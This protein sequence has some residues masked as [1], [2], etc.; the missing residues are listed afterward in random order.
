MGVEVEVLSGKE[1]EKGEGKKES[2]RP[3][4]EYIKERS[5]RRPQTAPDGGALAVELEILYGF[6][7]GRRRA[8]GSARPAHTR[9]ARDKERDGW[10]R[11]RRREEE[12]K[13]DVS[14]GGVKRTKLDGEQ[15]DSTKEAH[16]ISVLTWRAPD[17]DQR[18][19]SL[20]EH[21]A[22]MTAS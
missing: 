5:R 10:L 12:E 1:G 20:F 13:E 11:Q 6:H 22:P 19:R 3:V 8:A 18:Q 14:D 2:S 7:R 16:R 15:S 9:V 17:C 4:P 21:L